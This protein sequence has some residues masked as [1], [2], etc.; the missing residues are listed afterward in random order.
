MCGGLFWPD[1]EPKKARVEHLYA[2]ADGQVTP[3][4][5]E[6]I[7]IFCMDEFGPLNLQPR[8]GRQVNEA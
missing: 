4:T 3:E 1:Y 2:I 5:G 7:V 8:P 6:P